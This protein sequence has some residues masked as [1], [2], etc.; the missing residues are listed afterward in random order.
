[1]A[2]TTF[3]FLDLPLL[4]KL[5]IK[6]FCISDKITDS[7][8]VRSSPLSITK[9]Y[10]RGGICSLEQRLPNCG[11]LVKSSQCLFSYGFGAKDSFYIFKG[12]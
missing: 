3:V 2:L 12:L 6:Y 11:L 9:G 4:L 1:M 7:A 10:V 5:S 8:I